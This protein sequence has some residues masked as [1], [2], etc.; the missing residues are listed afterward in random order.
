MERRVLRSPW[1]AAVVYLLILV[2]SSRIAGN[3]CLL[4]PL[5][6]SRTVSRTAAA[7]APA[8]A[9]VVGSSH[10]HLYS[11][12]DA[13]GDNRG[14]GG[15]GATTPLTKKAEQSTFADLGLS[16]AVLAAVRSQSDWSTPTPIQRLAIPQLLRDGGGGGGGV[17]SPA[18]VASSSSV[19]CESPTGGGKTA[20]YALALLH[21]L[22]Q[23]PR[24][25][26]P[27]HLPRPSS[28]PVP[29]GQKVSALILCP[30]REL[31][32]QIG[33]VVTRLAAHS[34]DS[35]SRKKAW[36]IVVLHG[37]VPREPPM[38]ALADGGGGGAANRYPTIDILVATPGRL[39][40]VLQ[41][42][43]NKGEGHAS[44][45]DA[46]LE[47]RLLAAMDLRGRHQADQS[48]SLRQIQ[49][50]QLDRLVV[51]DDGGRAS[52]PGLLNQLEYF[53]LDEA[54]RLLSK[55][56]QA[57]MDAVL[58]LL[59]VKVPT[60]LFSATFPKQI[61]PRVNAVLKR[62]GGGGA[63]VRISCTNSDRSSS[64]DAGEG[65]ISVRLSKKLER[66]QPPV[67]KHSE[68]VGPASTIA[69]RTIRLEKRDR[70][71]AL[72]V[73]LKQQP[74]WDRVLVFVATRYAAEHVSRKLRRAGI[75][76]AELHGK[77]D[78]DARTRRL[79]NL[80]KGTIRV[81]V[82]TDVASRGLDMVGLPVVV[83]YDLPRS[84]ADFVHRVGRTG[85]AGRSGTAVTFCIPEG[86][87]QL[88]L[89]EKRCLLQQQPLQRETL[90]GLEPDE[91]KWR[92]EA[93]R[94]RLTVPGAVPSDRG[95][96]HDRMFGGIKSRRKSKKDK[97]REQA[98]LTTTTSIVDAKD[99]EP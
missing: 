33:S 20:C 47:K 62:I 89:I 25:R 11:N 44:V 78:Q 42:H 36:N 32:R 7:A 86:E 69:L 19:W 41:H 52:L 21:H 8:A 51:N 43:C 70:T 94:S 45:S 2:L 61:E 10:R 53:I 18:V 23:T 96:V 81:L 98:A 79:A 73:L 31:A 3:R 85:R 22:S 54:D 17:P 1:H 48:L 5:A 76:S 91:E 63:P 15:D 55:T 95:L 60:W 16:S 82:A 13:A 67:Q 84:S 75:E 24:P 46:A 27:H 49:K 6:V 65:N 64:L 77:L 38:A 88:D 35:T 90:P 39:V 92:S 29:A 9:V 71:Q 83:N 99:S 93:E 14:G 4:R 59:P 66:T 56:F 26:P 68:Q 40:D 37:G 57:E 74:D 58:D 97:L 50:L 72:R 34:G 80:Q 28:P 12:N 30:T 87:A